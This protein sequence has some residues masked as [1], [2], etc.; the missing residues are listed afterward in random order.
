M[1]V[2][3]GVWIYPGCGWKILSGPVRLHAEIH[4]TVS[5]KGSRGGREVDGEMT[6]L[7]KWFPLQG[8]RAHVLLFLSLLS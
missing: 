4:I 5:S 7:E 2:R 3:L 6:Y 1:F 8:E